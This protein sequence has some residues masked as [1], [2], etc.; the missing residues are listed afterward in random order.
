MPEI[1]DNPSLLY[2]GDTKVIGNWFDLSLIQ[3]NLSNV[4]T[5]AGNRIDF[6]FDQFEHLR[7]QKSSKRYPLCDLLFIDGQQIV[8]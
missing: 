1:I 5:C 3:T 8:F 7:F 4:I 2:A 6:D